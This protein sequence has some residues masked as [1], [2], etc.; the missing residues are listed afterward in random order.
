MR[1]RR[2]PPE[3]YAESEGGSFEPVF[4]SVLSSP[5]MPAPEL[6]AALLAYRAIYYLLPLVPATCLY[7]LLE[8]RS[9][10]RP[11]PVSSQHAIVGANASDSGHEKRA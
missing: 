2:L 5:A 8:A 11:A 6:I 1:L 4:V 3:D 9:S 10:H 7:F